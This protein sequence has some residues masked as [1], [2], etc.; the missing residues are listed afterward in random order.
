MF[1]VGVVPPPSVGCRLGTWARG[2]LYSFQT[3]AAATQAEAVAKLSTRV[4]LHVWRNAPSA[5]DP[6]PYNP[7]QPPTPRLPPR[8]PP[9][10]LP[11][12]SP[13]QR[14]SPP[15]LTSLTIVLPCRQR[16]HGHGYSL[17]AARLLHA[18]PR[19]LLLLTARFS[20]CSHCCSFAAARCSQCCSPFV[21]HCSCCWYCCSCC[22]YCSCCRSLLL[23]AAA[24]WS[25][26][27]ALFSLL[28]GCCCSM[29]LG[30]RSTCQANPM[31]FELLVLTSP[32][33]RSL[34]TAPACKYIPSYEL[35]GR[36]CS[37]LA[38]R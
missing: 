37:A 18:A 19:R 14:T 11:P 9:M 13:A 32:A 25:L 22:S 21:G 30:A 31:H 23:L 2:T 27:V 10:P 7:L 26:H 34:S 15:F 38:S 1:T 28:W 3:K 12:H 8:T 6:P 24:V 29:L 5:L 17:L 20:R 33:V 36:G 4:K 35:E 16:T